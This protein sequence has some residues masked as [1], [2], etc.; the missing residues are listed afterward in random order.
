MFLSPSPELHASVDHNWRL[1][2]TTT[3]SPGCSVRRFQRTYWEENVTRQITLWRA[4][5]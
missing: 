5:L 2:N 4:K 1:M 3:R